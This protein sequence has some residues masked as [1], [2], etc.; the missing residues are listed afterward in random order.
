MVRKSTWSTWLAAVLVANAAPDHCPLSRA[1]LTHSD[2][3]THLV[4]PQPQQL[5][6]CT[7][8]TGRTCCT[9]EDTLRISHAEPEI[10]LIGATRRCRDLLH[11]LM[12]SVCSPNQAEFYVRESI[13]SFE[14]HVLHVCES[15][16]NRLHRE[17]GSA[18]LRGAGGQHERIDLEFEDGLP[19]CREVGLRPVP[20][21]GDDAHV[22]FSSAQPRHG[23][24]ASSGFTLAVILLLAA[25]L[26][27][28]W[29][30]PP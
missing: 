21:M 28:K 23:P 2:F 30:G 16:C 18:A 27:Q 26:S 11:L 4:S 9:A 19:F 3:L 15:F 17:C 29:S 22:C 14:V 20:A 24:R 12:C 6:N 5:M 13:A 1:E 7:Q 8:Y 10:Q 25:S